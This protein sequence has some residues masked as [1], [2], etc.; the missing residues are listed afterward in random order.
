MNAIVWSAARTGSQTLDAAP[1]LV[2]RERLYLSQICCA[3]CEKKTSYAVGVKPD[4]GIDPAHMSDE[5]MITLLN[6]GA[7]EVRE[8][9]TCFC[10][11]CLHQWR[12]L[13]L[14]YF[15]PRLGGGQPGDG[16]WEG[17]LA[18]YGWPEGEIPGLVFERPFRCTLACCCYLLNPQALT[19][20]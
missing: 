14:G 15:A 8:E 7:F 19:M 20:T 6:P 18:G 16:L 13:K 3:Q 4:T 11:Y 9:S 12:E 2:L 1:G 10:R 17:G 5:V